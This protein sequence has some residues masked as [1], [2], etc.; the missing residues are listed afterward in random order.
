M[1]DIL[2]IGDGA[3]QRERLDRLHQ[4][5]EARG[6][7]IE[8]LAPFGSQRDWLAHSRPRVSAASCVIAVWTAASARDRWTAV[9]A[10]V[11]LE[12]RTLVSL[13]LDPVEL[14]RAFRG[15]D[16]VDLVGWAGDSES[17]LL[18]G[19]DAALRVMLGPTAKRR[20]TAPIPIPMR[21]AVSTGSAAARSVV[22]L[23]P[24]T[25]QKAAVM[26][27]L[28]P[29]RRRAELP[30]VAD[31]PA[32]WMRA[33]AL[34][35]GLYPLP[36]PVV[37]SARDQDEPDTAEASP[38]GLRVGL[39]AC[40]LGWAVAWV[41]GLTA[42]GIYLLS[43]L[44][45]AAASRIAIDNPLFSAVSGAAV[46][47]IGAGFMIYALSLRRVRMSSSQLGFVVFGW[48][49]GG[50]CGL[51]A[52]AHFGLPVV[53]RFYG[54]FGFDLG[55]VVAWVTAGVMGSFF[56]WFALRRSNPVL[57]PVH[58]AVSAGGFS[59]GAVGGA[60]LGWLVVALPVLGWGWL[61]GDPA[62]V[63]PSADSQTGMLVEL[64]SLGLIGAVAGAVYGAGGALVNFSALN[65]RGAA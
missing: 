48:G 13:V 62:A 60:I 63:A 31:A 36:P 34:F 7:V 52:A 61:R 65:R 51:L 11:A 64:L 24:A 8:R 43:G 47:L 50:G 16:S 25:D 56:T 45:G 3:P 39:V 18:D 59:L 49:F 4:A 17:P 26:E 21:S 9:G 35:D 44:Y 54:V 33:D 42:M 2:L 32:G 22:A 37:G 55:W 57:A 14:P 6:W 58:L 20:P 10:D 19:L 23:H 29:A 53:G 12:R 41:I 28:E 15:I 27:R 1:A 5:I 38:P 46:G 40:V 30:I